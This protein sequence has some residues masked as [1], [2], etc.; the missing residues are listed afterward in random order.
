[1]T[2]S[3]AYSYGPRINL[4][5]PG[6]RT[7]VAEAV[8]GHQRILTLGCATGALSADMKATGCVVTGVEIDAEAV[9]SQRPAGAPI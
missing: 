7:V 5:C 4:S 8:L 3:R 9:C 2:T 6:T 1:M